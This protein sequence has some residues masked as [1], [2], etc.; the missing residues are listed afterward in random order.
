MKTRAITLRPTNT[1]SPKRCTAIP[2]LAIGVIAVV[3]T[4]NIVTTLDVA[5][6]EEPYKIEYSDPLAEPWRISRF[7]EVDH[8]RLRCLEEDLDGNVWFGVQDG[9]LQYDGYSWTHHGSDQGLPPLEVKS[10]TTLANGDL[11][12]ATLSGLYR[13]SGPHWK[14]IFPRADQPT[15]GFSGEVIES[16]DGTIWA[17]CSRGLVRLTS[18]TSTLFTGR[19]F[20]ELFQREK[21]FNKVIPLPDDCLQRKGYDQTLGI[22]FSGNQVAAL[23]EN[24]PARG[25]GLRPKDRVLSVN[26]TPLR[27]VVSLSKAPGKQIRLRIERPTS[28]E[29]QTIVIATEGI[30]GTYLSPSTE[31]VLEDSA[32]RIWAG[33]LNGVLTM[34]PDGG[35]TWRTWTKSDCPV[36]GR[37]HQL[38]E[39]SD[40]NVWAFASRQANCAVYFDGQR[41]NDDHSTDL[42]VNVSDAVQVSDGSI[43]VSSLNRIYVYRNGRWKSYD[44]R[45]AKLPSRSQRMLSATDGSLWILGNNQPVV[46]IELSPD[47]FTSLNGPTYQCTDSTGAQWFVTDNKQR[48]V[49]REGGETISFGAEDGVIG[50][51]TNIVSLPNIGVVAIGAHRGTS[52]VATY[53]GQT[54]TRRTFPEVA[55]GFSNKAFTVTRQGHLWVGGKSKR[56]RGQVGGL[57][58]GVGDDWKHLRPPLAPPYLGWIV[59]LHDGRMMAGNSTGVWTSGGTHWWAVTD[60]LLHGVS[61]PDGT[62]DADGTVWLASRSNG[63]LRFQNDKWTSLDIAD[64]LASNEISAI[65]ADHQGTVWASTRDGLCRFDGQ[66][67]RRIDFPQELGRRSIQSNSGDGIWLDGVIRYSADP[68]PPRATLDQSTIT[69]DPGAQTIV[70]WSGVDKWNRTAANDLRW[71]WR[72]DRGAWSPFAKQNQ[73]AL[74]NLPVGNHTLEVRVSDGD[75]NV[76]P[77][78]R[79]VEITVLQPYWMRT[80]FLSVAA[81]LLALITWLATSLIRR[82][83]ALRRT[84]R[85]LQRAREELANQFAEKSAQFRAICDCSPVGIFV[86]NNANEIT[87]FNS[88]LAEV[89]GLKGEP[90]SQSTWLDAVHPDDRDHIQASW[91]AG[92][93]ANAGSQFSFSGRLMHPDGT[94]RNFNVV[95]DRIERD[96]QRLGY[97]GA[98]E[99]VTEKLI[100]DQELKESNLQL[101]EALDRLANAQEI[102]I[103]R[104]RLNALGRMAAGVA[105]D[106]NNSL[107]PLLTYAEMLEQ[108]SDL[109][110]ASRNW[111][112][113]IRLGVTDT[114]ETVRRLEHFYR[115]S[116]NREFLE[117]LDLDHI[118]TQSVE[119]TRPRWQNDS[120]ST[121]KQISVHTDFSANPLVKG[122]GTQLRAVLTNLIFN[123]VD[124]I[125]DQGQ[126][127]IRVDADESSAIVDVSDS[128]RGM[129]AEQ[130]QHCTEP[131]YTTNTKGSGLGLSECDGIV[132]QHGGKLHVQSRPGKGTTV[133]F[134]LPR[135]HETQPPI[136][137]D[138]VPTAAA[139]DADADGAETSRRA[140]DE[141][142]VL[143]IDDDELVRQ[144]TVAVLQSLQLS[145][146]TAEDGPTALKRLQQ[147]EFQLVLCDQGLPGMD[148]LTVLK[149][150]KSRQPNLPVIMVSGWSLPQYDGVQPDGFLEKPFAMLDLTQLIESLLECA[151]A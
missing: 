83:L 125:D 2:H 48:I 38:L 64:G 42:G 150:I 71:S 75:A 128:G 93:R 76:S 61:C 131:F 109:Q 63:V 105:H 65:H 146:E 115:E 23:S 148:G 124:A 122:N 134:R 10:L 62:V 68:D 89:A 110:G 78:A 5:I 1:G 126:I 53:D 138:S 45:D 41:W 52:A 139:L 16:H 136:D 9:V 70:S 107:T 97:V 87:Y 96:G 59:E 28:G 35:E 30:S 39:T 19:E 29:Q 114:A 25:A 137:E 121:G 82:T 66:R 133:Q 149:H 91:H 88:Y 12:A 56:N 44:A 130:L 94:I 73:V 51:P 104:E 98:L 118:V 67:F 33:G 20:V 101:R 144:S 43:W 100:A 106:I 14:R 54:W 26:G 85:Q 77:A 103:K 142:R 79:A 145:V 140:P 46:R 15:W 50:H 60:P 141:F 80:W 102:A 81:M 4:L 74:D 47:K 119:L 117:V 92:A 86:T 40:G 49:R 90:E 84:N 95:A 36:Q 8:L 129:S 135:E 3:A 57:V 6:A 132:R 34:S 143:C 99:D 72:V 18:E 31:F 69:V 151:D 108:D 7:P 32:D 17:S 27:S 147:Q 58:S 113:L 22:V 120:L 123:A 127:T 112:K 21:L 111:L 13:K 55:E 24:S 11:V 116:H 37:V